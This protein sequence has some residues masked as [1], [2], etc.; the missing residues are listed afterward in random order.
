MSIFGKPK[1]G[2][3]VIGPVQIYEDDVANALRERDKVRDAHEI[4]VAA[5]A[6][7]L[8]E[9]AFYGVYMTP[10]GPYNLYLVA[11]KQ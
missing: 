3:P 9:K 2:K 11:E 4:R 6:I 10:D 5:E 7:A 1:G 8:G